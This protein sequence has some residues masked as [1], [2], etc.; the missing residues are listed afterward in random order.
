RGLQ[1]TIDHPEETFEICLEYVP[2]AGGENR[3]IQMA[4]LKESIKF[5]ESERLGYSDP[6]AWEASQEFMLEVGL[7]ETETDV[8]AMFSNEFVLE[9]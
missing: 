3:A 7:V 9:P 8:E 2:E 6:A 4:V 1:Y 5:W